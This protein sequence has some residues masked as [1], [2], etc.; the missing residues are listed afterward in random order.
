MCNPGVIA[1]PL[2]DRQ[3]NQLPLTNALRQSSFEKVE[4][5]L[6]GEA[7]CDGLWVLV[8]SKSAKGL[9]TLLQ[10]LKSN[11]KRGQMP[12]AVPT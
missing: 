9:Q 8:I 3:S 10:M 5:E 1:P 6:I 11:Q 4:A 12:S 7:H 2:E